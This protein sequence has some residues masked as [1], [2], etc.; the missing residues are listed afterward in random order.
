MADDDRPRLAPG[1]L[2]QYF[3]RLAQSYGEGE[4]FLKRRES[5]IVAI[6]DEIARA[7]RI[8][9]LGCANGRYLRDFRKAAPDAIVIGADLTHEM[10]LEARA[11]SGPGVPL[12]RADATAL[13]LRDGTLD[14]IFAS[15]V[16]QFVSDKDATMRNL[17]RCLAPGG[18][19]ILTVGGAGLR[20]ALRGFIGEEQWNQLAGVA[21]PSRRAIVARERAQIHREA[22]SRAGLAIEERDAPFSVTW[23][24]LVEWIDLRWGPFMND[25]QRAVATGILDAMSPQLASRSFDV[26]ERLLLGRKTPP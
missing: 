4:F 1:N 25:E 8:F 10:L 20:G 21:F 22:M 3:G 2:A 5:A 13:P 26:N 9:D 11:R 17:A 24:G 18:A 19:V 6:A 7:R 12:I 14:I 16:L 23:A 15:H